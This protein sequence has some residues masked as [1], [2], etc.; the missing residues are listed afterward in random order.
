METTRQSKVSRLLQKDLG[1]IFQQE[2][3]NLF[4]GKMISVTTVRISPDLGLAKVYLS[5]FPSDKSEETLEVVKMNT[6]NIR[7]ILGT[8]VGKQLRVVPELA[9][10]IDDSLDYIEN[11]DNLL[12]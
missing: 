2:G 7:R 3:R 1:L 8:K 5:I 4:G 6:K 10:Y 9:F 12:S 11:I